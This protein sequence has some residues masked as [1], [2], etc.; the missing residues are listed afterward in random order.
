VSGRLHAAA[1]LP[2]HPP[3]L[4]PDRLW[5]PPSLLSNG[6]QGLFPWGLIGR[7]AKLITHLH[8]VPRSR[9]REAI[10]SHPNTP[11]WRG[12]QLK[13]RDNFTFYPLTRKLE[14]EGVSP[15]SS[16]DTVEEST[17]ESKSRAGLHRVMTYRKIPDLTGDRSHVI[18]PVTSPLA[19]F[20]RLIHET[21]SKTHRTATK[22]AKG[23]LGEIR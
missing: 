23:I 18:E 1:T 8:L 13:H 22:A 20:S 3:P 10:P 6:Y 15:T 17:Q 12:A 5:G 9:T 19:D 21:G 4:C 11:S 14:G 7:G 16:H 2:R